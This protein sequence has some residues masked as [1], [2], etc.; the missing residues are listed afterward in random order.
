MIYTSIACYKS[1]YEKFK[2]KK[3]NSRGVKDKALRR[4]L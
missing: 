1:D 4:F 2:I 3:E